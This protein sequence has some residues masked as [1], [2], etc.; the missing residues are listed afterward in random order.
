MFLSLLFAIFRNVIS[1]WPAVRRSR[2]HRSARVVHTL[3]RMS[4]SF[5]LYRV[6]CQSTCC[7]SCCVAS[8]PFCFLCHPPP[9]PPL[10]FCVLSLVLTP[11]STA[12]HT[13]R[14]KIRVQKC[15][16][17]VQL[18]GFW[19]LRP[20]RQRHPLHPDGGPRRLHVR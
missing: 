9:P 2:H 7:C 11:P 5:R 13:R 19:E 12:H 20:R 1:V 8:C 6:P 10:Y 15:L 18:H 17:P 16:D 3:I 14:R 4:G